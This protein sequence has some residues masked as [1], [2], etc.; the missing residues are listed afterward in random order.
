MGGPDLDVMIAGLRQGDPATVRQF[1]DRYGSGLERL[2]R[3]NMASGLRR[4]VGPDDVVQSV[5]RTFLRRAGDGQFVLDDADGLWRLL[6]AITLTKVREKARYHL[7]LKRGYHLEVHEEPG[8]EPGWVDDGTAPDDAVAFAE[9]F[10]RLIDGLDDV[11]R[12]IVD[13]KLQDRSNGEVAE[14]LGRSERTVRRILARMRTRWEALLD[15][16]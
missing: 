1:C 14:R 5:Y 16:A 15:A 12:S 2:A 9:L 7:R 6:C 10:E 4:R 13:L 8:T 11:E 3:S